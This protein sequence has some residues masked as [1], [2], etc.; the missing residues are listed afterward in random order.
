M[1]GNSSRPSDVFVFHFPKTWRTSWK[2]KGHKSECLTQLMM[3]VQKGNMPWRCS[4]LESPASLGGRV[5][6]LTSS[7][8]VK[9]VSIYRSFPSVKH[10]FMP[11]VVP[12]SKEDTYAEVVMPSECRR[13]P[14]KHDRPDPMVQLMLL[15]KCFIIILI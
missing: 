9:M 15:R 13:R 7:S 12:P 11:R 5:N 6:R 10:S 2:G 1:K 14:L 4:N 3:R 8:W